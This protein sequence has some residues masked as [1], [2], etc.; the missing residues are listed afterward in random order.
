MEMEKVIKGLECHQI[1]KDHRINC[2]DCPYHCD[3]FMNGLNEMHND[4]I[5]L[6]KEQQEQIDKLI[7]ESAS[8]AEMAEGLKELLKEYKR[9]DGCPC[10]HCT[11]WE[12]DEVCEEYKKW[13]DT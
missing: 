7:E 11:E 2:S 4:A 12:C 10:T 6:L 5:A 13:K 1:D 9:Q 8:N 3:E